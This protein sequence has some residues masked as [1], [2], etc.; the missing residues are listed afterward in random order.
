MFEQL[1]R[2]LPLQAKQHQ[3]QREIKEAALRASIEHKLA[4]YKPEKNKASF[5]G[6]N[7]VSAQ[8]YESL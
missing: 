8:Q 1:K 3:R 4:E 6:P 2:K 5:F 7:T